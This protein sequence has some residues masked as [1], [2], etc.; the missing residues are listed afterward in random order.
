VLFPHVIAALLVGGIAN[1]TQAQPAAPYPDLVLRVIRYELDAG[2]DYEAEKVTGTARLVVRNVSEQPT[3]EVPVLTY[4]LMPVTAV[5]DSAG[6]ALSFVQEVIALEDRPRQQV[7][8]VRV[9]LGVPLQPGGTTTVVIRYGG[10]L[11]GYAETGSAY[12]R[13]HVAPDF[14]ILR[15]DGIGFPL[16]G[17]PSNRVNRKP[18]V[19]HFDYLARIT[20]PESLWVANGGRLLGRT[21]KQG[22]ATFTYQNIKPAWRMDFA[23]APYRTLERGKFRVVYFP[24][25]SAG[26]TLLLDA[27]ERSVTL[28]QEW[29]GPL[30]G[31]ASFAVIELPDGFGS[32]ADVTSILQT[33]AAFRDPSQRR[34]LYHEISHMLDVPPAEPFS[35]RLNEGL[36]TYLEYLTADHLDGTA[37]LAPRL[38]L[39][40]RWLQ[41]VIA[42]RAE[43]AT[44]PMRDYG[45]HDLTDFSYSAGMILFAILHDVLGDEEFRRV[46][47]ECHA[48]HAVSGGTLDHFVQTARD[49]S[50]RDLS[51]VFDDWIYSPRWVET[52]T[53][54]GSIKQL[55]D[56]YRALSSKAKT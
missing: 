44:I 6:R 55:L 33:A 30:A 49:V 11:L 39:V 18:G 27:V 32:Q 53:R 31:G 5:T 1:Y 13:D 25:D 45:R 34:Q 28:Y 38:E 24:R 42:K 23:I 14:T 26:A 3:S 50:S 9:A 47:R 15:D 10:Y 35:P 8:F 46:I 43:L 40:R 12:V 21:S 52:V 36:A 17:Y 54:T 7:N 4:R 51:A 37:Q 20:V 48:R 29:F 16:L 2:V 22:Q 56:H 19:T 41:G